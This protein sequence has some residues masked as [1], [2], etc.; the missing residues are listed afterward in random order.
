MMDNEEGKPTIY[1]IPEI[2]ERTL[3]DAI[4]EGVIPEVFTIAEYSAVAGFVI[5]V[6]AKANSKLAGAF[7]AIL[8]GCVM[9]HVMYKM[10]N[11]IKQLEFRTRWGMRIAY[12]VTLF[13]SVALLF[14]ILLVILQMAAV[15]IKG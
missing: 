10:T 13:S 6:A 15:Q 5:F 8:F 14:G 7:G 3:F 9:W 12:F 11:I 1:R 4:V 2:R